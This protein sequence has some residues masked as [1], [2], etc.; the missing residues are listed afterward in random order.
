MTSR[1]GGAAWWQ[2]L[3]WDPMP[4]LLDPA[5][6]NLLWRALVDVVGRPRQSP[7]VVRARGGANAQAPVADLLAGLRPD[8]EWDAGGSQWRH[9]SGSVWRLVAAVQLGA[10]PA[11]PRLAAA[12]PA[13]LTVERDGSLAPEREALPCATTRALAALAALGLGGDLRFSEA[14]AWLGSIEEARDGGWPCA[15][16][17]GAH[18]CAVTAVALLEASAITDEVA[19]RGLAKRAAESLLASGVGRLSPRLGWPN[20]LRT[21]LA[22]GLAALARAGV[23]YDSRLDEGL[24]RLQQLQDAK[25]SWRVSVSAPRSLPFDGAVDADGWATLHAVTAIARFAEAARL[26]RMYPHKPG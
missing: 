7:A 5:R 25:A 12:A 22:E 4:R 9:Y 16:H 21:D 23:G 6:P 14:L 15:R 26:P 8:G 20:L 2:A 11:D 19:G 13:V 10:D 17:G 18:G 3:R 1:S 24:G